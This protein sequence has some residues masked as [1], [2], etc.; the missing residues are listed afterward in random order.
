VVGRI[1]VSEGSRRVQRDES[2]SATP[3]PAI[4]G[5]LMHAMGRHAKTTSCGRPVVDSLHVWP[6]LSFPRA[7]GPHCQECLD[8]ADPVSAEETAPVAVD[9]GIPAPMG[10]LDDIVDLTDHDRA[11]DASAG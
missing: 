9:T 3:G 2:S 7:Y 1:V 4:P 8:A 10:G 11:L 6:S 5:G